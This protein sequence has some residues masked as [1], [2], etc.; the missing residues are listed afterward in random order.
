VYTVYGISPGNYKTVG[1][2]LVD[3]SSHGSNSDM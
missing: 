3:L 2:R 1:G